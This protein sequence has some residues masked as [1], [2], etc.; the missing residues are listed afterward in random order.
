M[1]VSVLYKISKVIVQLSLGYIV[2]MSGTVRAELKEPEEHAKKDVFTAILDSR[3]NR[4]KKNLAVLATNPM[5]I[6]AVKDSN[7]RGDAGNMSNSQW[8]AMA[9]DDPKVLMLN[10]NDV[11]ELLAKF[12]QSKA[13]E[14]LNVRDIKGFL[15]AFSSS[16]TKPLVYNAFD[17]P[18]FING[19]K[20]VW[21]ASETKPDPTTHKMAVQI[22]T[23]VMDDG[24]IIGV[25][26]SSVTAE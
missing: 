22:A 18:G 15:V 2:L 9:E 14:K 23:P 26:H 13:F 6:A 17:R 1:S 24:K 16:N 8:V 10:K 7:N 4:Y 11:G 12:E 21:S 5:I 25:I 19:L 20:G 3:V